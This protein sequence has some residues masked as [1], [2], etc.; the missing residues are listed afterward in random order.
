LR[1]QVVFDPAT[2][3]FPGDEAANALLA[4]RYRDAYPL[5]SV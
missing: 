4:K 3:T 5:P 1:R 2:E